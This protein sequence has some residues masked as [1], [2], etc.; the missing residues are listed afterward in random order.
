VRG[1]L[2]TL[3]AVRLR[4]LEPGDHRCRTRSDLRRV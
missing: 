1:P 4:I 2:I 3:K